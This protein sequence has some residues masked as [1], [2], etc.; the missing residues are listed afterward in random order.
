MNIVDSSCWID[1]FGDGVS[2]NFAEGAIKDTANL[3][4]PGITIYEVYKKLLLEETEYNAL[5]AVAAM[6]QGKIINLDVELSLSAAKYSIAHK[7]PMADAIIY[8]SAKKF[9]CT[10]WTC[11]KHFKGLDLVNYFEK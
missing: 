2:C 6:K 3:N 11:D 5:L 9:C 7:L 8:A 4:V 10:L 1:Y